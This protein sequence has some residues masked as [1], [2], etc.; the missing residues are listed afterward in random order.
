MGRILSALLVLL[1]SACTS[2]SPEAVSGSTS[3]ETSDEA[4]TTTAPPATTAPSE[5]RTTAASTTTEAEEELVAV[6]DVTYVEG[7]GCTSVGPLEVPAGDHS[8]LLRDP[9]GQLENLW[10]LRLD[11]GRTLQDVIDA[12][13][14]PGKWYPKPDWM[15][16]TVDLQSEETDDGTVFIKR[17]EAPGPHAMVAGLYYGV[18]TP[19]DRIWWWCDP[20]FRVVENTE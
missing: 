5:T 2:A 17:L 9:T 13:P 3:T 7:E 10:V 20:S 6:F 18:E 4:P 1:L 19:E 8:F 16:Y 12:A 15:H 14:G 11:E